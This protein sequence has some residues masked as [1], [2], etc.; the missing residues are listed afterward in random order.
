PGHEGLCAQISPGPSLAL[1]AEHADAAIFPGRATRIA[2]YACTI[3][4]NDAGNPLLCL[5]QGDELAVDFDNQLDEASTIHW[6]GLGVD[7]G[8]DG[9][10]LHPVA[11]G[12]QARYRFKVGNRAGLYWYHAHPHGRT[13]LQLQQGLAGLLLIEDTEERAL[14]EQ[15]GLVWG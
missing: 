2:R 15:L 5:R 8:N 9:S 13:G 6:H 4:G 12:A 11:A 3:D 10:G 1:R 7:E 14:R